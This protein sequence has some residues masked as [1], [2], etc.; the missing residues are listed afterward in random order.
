MRKAII[1]TTLA[2][3]GVTTIASAQNR[4]PRECRQEIVQ[5]CGT[6]R[7]QIRGCLGEKHRQ[8]SGNCRADLR[9]RMGNR[10][11]RGQQT[12]V[13]SRG[14]A[15]T[16]TISQTIRYGEH[17]RQAVDFYA[18]APGQAPASAGSSK[19]PL[20]MFVHGGGWAFGKR[21]LVNAKPAHFTAQG[22]AFVSA[23]YRVLPDAPVEDQA[24]DV[25]AAIVEMRAQA[26]QLGFDADR[27]ILMGHSAGAHLSALVSTD[28]SLL[29][30][31]LAA[32][33]GVVLLDGAGYDVA[34]SM[35]QPGR[36]EGRLYRNA[37]GDDPARHEAL[38]PMTHVG[39]GDAP[40]WLVLYVAERAASRDQ[41]RALAKKLRATGSKA[42]AVAISGTD[43]GRMNREIGTTETDPT[44]LAIDAF[45]KGIS[46]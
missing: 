29:G 33:K 24:L 7:S 20:V 4:L 5:L 14:P 46:N 6:D 31:A 37:F 3:L 35:E 40:E 25:A 27:I 13:Q 28:E 23:G 30:E 8:L 34:A 10:G 45:L 18:P 44:T 43:H 38:S 22:Y 36:F 9:E 17:E 41:S 11:D 15:N 21:A 2:A 42:R 12:R 1:A 39:G 32:I 26:G 16:A 19:P